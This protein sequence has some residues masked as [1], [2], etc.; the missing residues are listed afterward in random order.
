M[1]LDATDLMAHRI[2]SSPRAKKRSPTTIAAASSEDKG[3]AEHPA[4]RH[5]C[6]LLPPAVLHDGGPGRRLHRCGGAP[7]HSAC[8]RMSDRGLGI[9]CQ[10]VPALMMWQPPDGIDV[11]RWVC[12]DPPSQWQRQRPDLFRKRVNN[13]AGCDTSRLKWKWA[14]RG[15]SVTQYL[16]RSNLCSYEFP[17]LLRQARCK[18]AH[19]PSGFGQL[20]SLAAHGSRG[21]RIRYKALDS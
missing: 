14:F 8:R 5:G 3:W 6:R 11:L 12:E 21:A 7:R 20:S 17:K 4:R 18:R 2:A 13:H 19:S 16:D 9:R 1:R 15:L 10:L